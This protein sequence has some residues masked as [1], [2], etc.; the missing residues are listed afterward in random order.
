MRDLDF[1]GAALEDTWLRDQFWPAYGL[2]AET[3]FSLR[4]VILICME[5][6]DRREIADSA[7][8]SRNVDAA[9]RR[10]N[11]AAMRLS[12]LIEDANIRRL[13][14]ERALP[15]ARS[16]QLHANRQTTIRNCGPGGMWDELLSAYDAVLESIRL[17]HI[18]HPTGEMDQ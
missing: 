1:F 17:A 2:L 8:S 13:V 6:A 10:S 11:D 9:Q 15:I 14:G 3:V 5:A 7:L 16:D 18:A 4:Q 12:I